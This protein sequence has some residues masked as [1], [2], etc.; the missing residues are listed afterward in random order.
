MAAEDYPSFFPKP[1]PYENQ[2][3]AMERIADALE[4][5]RDVLFEGAC[6]TGKTLAALAPALAYARANDKTVVITTN[7]HQQ[8]RQFI[9]E[10]REINGE[11]PINAV[12]FKGKSSMCHID[13]DYE[14]CQVLRDNTHDLVDAQQELEELQE[15][16]RELLERSQK[17]SAEAAESRQTVLE[18]IDQLEAQI[19]DLRSANTCEHYYNNVTRNDDAFFGW[20][21]D[22]VR[23][24]EDIYDYAQD[25]G[26]C[27]YELLKEGMDGVDLAVA[28]YHHLLDPSIRTQFFRWLGRD[29]GDVVAV[30]D[31]AHNVEDA[32]RDH[33]TRTLSERTLDGAIDEMVDRED[34][35]AEAAL[36][37]FRPFRDALVDTYDES[38]GFGDR[39]A[40]GPNWEDVPVANEEGRD[41]LTLA[42]LRQYEGPDIED[43]LRLAQQI[44]VDLDQQYEEAYK[45]GDANTRKESQTLTASVFVEAYLT[46]GDEL[47]Q[48]PTLA[49]RRDEGRDEIIGRAELYTCIPRRVTEPLF[50]QVHA[51][52]LMSATL[53]PFDVFADVLGLDDPETMAY[54][55]SFPESRRRT[56][57]VDVPPLFASKREDRSVQRTIADALADVVRFAPG[58]ALF[59]FPSYGE[60][61]RYHDLLGDRIDA[62]R[63][64]DRA[65]VS[66][67]QRRTE[68]VADD[69]AV[70]FTSLWATLAEGV[71]F[72]GDDAR[73]VAVVGVPYPHLDE[74]ADA[75]QTAYDEAF[76]D[77]AD[78]AGWRYAVEIPTVRKTRQALGRVLRSPEDFGARVLLDRRYTARSRTEMGEYSVNETFPPEE[79]A[80]LVDVQPR[81]LKY[82]MLNFFQDVDA[83]DGD[84]PTP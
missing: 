17:G 78:D 48:Y 3:P 70:M 19:E 57:A 74:R 82:A 76:G 54:G 15:R 9:H 18:E 37:V 63:Y 81:K 60:A 62:T 38:F 25:R 35:R 55:L 80:E 50:D 75:V 73:T 41:D 22:D 64:L 16:E 66:V 58:N 71:S 53:R 1:E 42:F 29:P 65:G 32:A 67:E 34:P 56:F 30:F 61:E 52:V 23:T 77:R 28:N 12:V 69:N 8:M 49:V 79:R 10:A 40:V 24:P 20:L 5:G 47:G 46:E 83:Y 6:G 36:R 84:P 7:V 4:E 39:E 11:Q 14:E 2:E 59:F 43:D 26:Y 51:S 27:G 13:V 44:G 31:E 33:A 21:Y 45:R 72:D 68:F